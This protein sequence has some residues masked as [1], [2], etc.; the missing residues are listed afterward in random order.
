MLSQLG[1]EYLSACREDEEKLRDER[2]AALETQ[3]QAAE[4]KERE[5]AARAEAAETER[6][7]AEREK[8][9]AEKFARR[10]KKQTR[11]AIGITCVAIVFLAAAIWFAIYANEREIAAHE[12][13]IAAEASNL[14]HPLDFSDSEI[15]PKQAEGLLQLTRRDDD[16]K[17][18]FLEQLL[19]DKSVAGWFNH[20]PR[21]I[22]NAAIGLN[23]E[24]RR[25]FLERLEAGAPE[26]ESEDVI[27]VARALA[28]LKLEGTL[29]PESLIAAIQGTEDSYQ[30]RSLG[31]GLAAV[32]QLMPETEKTASLLF[33]L[34]KNPLLP[35]DP[36]TAAIR[37]RFPDA[38]PAEQGFWAL[39]EWADKRYPNI[40][41]DA[42]MKEPAEIA[43]M[44]DN[45]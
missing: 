20:Q 39:V 25:W 6:S 29:T 5:A 26:D 7:A 3:R 19:S 31:A 23:Q 43:A 8:V 15:N 22:L 34:L 35:R 14:W 45:E 28:L 18:A 37:K 38:P 11:V 13:Q 24:R 42:P 12:K 44:L 16:H 33:E 17:K 4:A 21:T 30:L 36:I 32:A 2:I 41:L 40:D 9:Q 10:S 1:A 27:R